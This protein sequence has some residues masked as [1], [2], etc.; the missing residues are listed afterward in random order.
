MRWL[1]CALALGLGL[2]LPV[3]AADSTSKARQ[4]RKTQ[5]TAKKANRIQPVSVGQK[6]GLHHTQ[7]PLS[8]R[9]SVAY[10]LDQQT[11]EVLFS[12]NDDA[13]LPIASITKLMT[14]LVLHEA[15]LDLSEP[16]TITRAD[17]D[18]LKGSHS[19]LAV[20]ATLTR[21]ELLHLALMAS[22]N[23]A[24][25][26]L[27]RTFPEGYPEFIRR[28]NVKAML[29]GMADTHFVE[30]TGLSSQNRSSAKDL[31]VLV[32]HAHQVEMLRKMST[33]PS[34]SV[35]VGRRKLTF[36]TT[37]RLVKNP[38]WDIG[39]QKTGY[40]AEAGQ[41]LVMQATV[42]G[43]QL[44]MVFLDS[45]GKLSRVADAERVRRWLERQESVALSQEAH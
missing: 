26:A 38:R 3:Q 13:V 12:K 22:E 20:G 30:P 34:Y 7:D 42:A 35:H 4:V 16:V 2:N 15:D 41:C 8:L 37:N 36:N 21:G 40:I 27:A 6:T 43:R 11:H 45:A 5:S 19:R 24:A 9:S 18:T 17:I 31:A 14:A 29:L 23:R 39:L 1:L 32:E 25:H 10:V 33:T 28:M 44:I